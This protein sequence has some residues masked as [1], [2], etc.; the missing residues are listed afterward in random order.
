[1]LEDRRR[2]EAV[3]RRVAEVRQLQLQG[4]LQGAATLV[5]QGLLTFPS[6]A[7]LVKLHSSIKKGIEEVRRREAEESKRHRPDAD[8]LDDLPCGAT[9]TIWTISP[10]YTPCR[11]GSAQLGASG[12]SGG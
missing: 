11:R 4:D 2:Q 12:G 1:M 3:D 9:R 7:R 5:E 8:Q 10:R 6:E